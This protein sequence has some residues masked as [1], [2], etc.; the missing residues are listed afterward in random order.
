MVA[1]RDLTETRPVIF[2]PCPLPE[3]GFA[4]WAKQV[5][6]I[7]ERNANKVEFRFLYGPE[8]TPKPEGLPSLFLAS[9]AYAR[10][11]RQLISREP[12]V[13]SVL[14]PSF[15][16]PNVLLAAMLPRRCGYVLRVSGN[17]LAKGN[18]LT[19]RLRISMIRRAR[20]VIALNKAQYSCLGELGVPIS[21]RRLIP[22]AVGDEFRHPSAEERAAAR[23]ALGLVPGDRVVGSVGVL[24]ERKQQ[25]A[26]I[27]AAARLENPDMVVVLCGP[28]SGG[29]E[30]DAEY[31]EAC[32]TDARK[33]GVRLIMTG[34]LEDVQPVLWALDV[35][36]LPSLAEGMPN[37]LLE[38]LACGL[39]CVGSNIPGIRDLLS[40]F[41]QGQIFEAGNIEDLSRVLSEVSVPAM[42]EGVIDLFRAPT[43]DVQIMELLV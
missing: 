28:E 43:V 33:F 32:R 7:A 11:C 29:S 38:A 13:A 19:Y 3:N 1:L 23:E 37:A 20:H 9:L 40:S 35:F 15:F 36:V 24:C 22:V 2:V 21:Q 14:F 10:R 30:A 16:L 34:M 12:K 6:R 5:Q 18:P 25:R 8:F 4:G 31:A 26:L 42:M 39:P 17:E 27:A 41:E